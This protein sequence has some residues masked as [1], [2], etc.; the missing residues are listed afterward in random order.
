MSDLVILKLG[1]SVITDKKTPFSYR[2][3]VVARIGREVFRCWPTPLL[4]IHGGGSFGHT[5]A[6]EYGIAQGYRELRQLEGFVKTIQ[7]MRE[8]N[9]RIVQTLIETG[10]G[11]VGMPASLLFVTRDGAIETALL[12]T[13]FSAL[14]IGV[15]PVTCGDAVFDRERKFTILSGDTI[16]VYLAKRLKAR[17]LVFATD[18]DGIYETDRNTGERKLVE[19]LDQKRHAS[20]IY[21]AVNDVT[22]GM[23]SKVD[24]AF[25]AV[26]AGVDVIFVNGL[27]EGRVEA[28]VKGEKVKGTRLAKS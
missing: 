23:F 26:A 28:A 24:E 8:L 15:I 12:D 3:E 21:H 22:G 1:G 6:R 20:I 16:A 13:L 2:S 4:I 14:D 7:A 9:S 11:A 25:G 17:R 10:I 5:I 19:E 27:V 18:V